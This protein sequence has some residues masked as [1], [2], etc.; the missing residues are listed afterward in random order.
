MRDTAKVFEDR[1][2][3]GEWRVEWFDDD[4]C[5]VEIFTGPNARERAR[6]YADEQYGTFEEIKTAKIAEREAAPAH[7]TRVGGSSPDIKS[8]L[9]EDG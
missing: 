4:G 7:R 9:P 1:E 8:F 5:E 6:R 2:H 3:A